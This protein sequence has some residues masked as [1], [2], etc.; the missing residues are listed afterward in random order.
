MFTWNRLF[1]PLRGKGGEG[2][3][4]HSSKP[5]RGMRNGWAHPHNIF[6]K[7]P[8]SR[9]FQAQ[10]SVWFF[11]SQSS[12]LI[13]ENERTKSLLWL[14]PSS[15]NCKTTR[16]CA[17]TKCVDGWKSYSEK[18]RKDTSW[19]TYWNP[20]MSRRR[21]PQYRVHATILTAQFGS[22]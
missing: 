8:T 16:W 19:N 1:V 20:G 5:P 6:F 9:F 17:P 2:G 4:G 14:F 15:D 21:M 13:K 18:L 3:A 12:Q 10:S 7:W 22:G 11:P